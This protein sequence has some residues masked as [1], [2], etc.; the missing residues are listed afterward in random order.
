MARRPGAR[1]GQGWGKAGA[2]LGQ[3]WGSGGGWGGAYRGLQVSKTTATSTE[4]IMKT[5]PSMK[6]RKKKMA[7][8]PPAEFMSRARRVGAITCEE[9]RVGLEAGW[10]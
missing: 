9:L 3:G 5:D 1:L 6:V 8:T 4:V 10:G 7:N 2:R